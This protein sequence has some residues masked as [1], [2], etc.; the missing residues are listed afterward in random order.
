MPKEPRIRTLME[1]QHV[2]R[3]ETLLESGEKYFSH[4]F[5]HS[6][7]KIRTKNFVLVVSEVLRLLVNILT[8]DDKYSLSV[9]A[10]V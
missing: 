10:S 5:D 3:S 8:P 2:K 4:I 9:K 7:K 6:E 1:S